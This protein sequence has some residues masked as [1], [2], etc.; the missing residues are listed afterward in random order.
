[1]CC[2]VLL[3]RG[4]SSSLATDTYKFA[5]PFSF[6]VPLIPKIRSTAPARNLRAAFGRFPLGGGKK[7]EV[8]RRTPSGSDSGSPGLS[9]GKKRSNASRGSLR[10]RSS[11]A[12]RCTHETVQN[13][14]HGFLLVYSRSI[15]SRVY[16]SRGIAGYPRCCEQ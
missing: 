14:A 5:H 2:L 9:G 12:T 11:I 8:R 6:V 16:F 13:G 10:I 7:I 4:R 3:L 1:M 15:S